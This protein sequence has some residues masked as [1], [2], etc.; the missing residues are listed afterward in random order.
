MTVRGTHGVL[1]DPVMSLVVAVPKKELGYRIHQQRM[2]G[3]I[4]KQL[5]LQTLKTAALM[6]ALVNFNLYLIGISCI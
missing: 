1:G 2:V 3:P 5:T 6:A 4:A